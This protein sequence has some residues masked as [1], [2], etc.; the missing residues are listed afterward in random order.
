MEQITEPEIDLF[1]ENLP[2]MEEIKTLSERVHCGE[3]N[4]LKFSEQVEANMGSNGQKA[5]LSVGIGL[6]ILGRNADAIEKLQ[7]AQDCKEKFIYLAYALRRAGEFEKAKKV[8][9]MT[10][11]K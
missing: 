5:R 11:T 6:Y 7:K 3:A 1:A 8:S 9:N 10:P 4:L 2:S